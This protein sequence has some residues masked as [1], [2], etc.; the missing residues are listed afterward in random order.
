MKKI[1]AVTLVSGILFAGC[2]AS[3]TKSVDTQ[4][5]PTPQAAVPGVTE[6]KI[7][8][9]NFAFAPSSLTV[10]AGQK[11]LVTNHDGMGHTVTA[12][13]KSFDTGT[14][15]Q[16]ETKTFTAPMK[17]GSYHFSCAFHIRMTGVL[18]V[19]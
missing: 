17:A 1:L 7:D 14:I 10:K 6:T 4:T 8:I 11:I 19:Q 9:Q 16:N 13:D 15:N 2:S 12:K 18:I 3:Q 5:S